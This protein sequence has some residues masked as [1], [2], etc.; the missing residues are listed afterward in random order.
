[1][2]TLRASY[3]VIV[4]LLLA[5]P[6]C[7]DSSTLLSNTAPGSLEPPAAAQ[8]GAEITCIRETVEGCTM[9]GLRLD[10]PLP[11]NDALA[12][13]SDLY[14]TPIAVYRTDGVCVPSIQFSPVEEPGR[15]ASRFAYVDA[16]DIARRRMEAVD[17][18]LAP[19]ITGLHISQ[20]YWTQWSTEWKLAGRDGVE[21][22][23]I[24]VWMAEDVAARVGADPRIA[25]AVTLAWRRTDSV[26]PDYPGELL[27]DG[28]AFPG[29]SRPTPP[30]C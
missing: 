4:I 29:L 1:M 30:D 21:I 20:S 5:L 10:P 11:L 13:A 28:R 3:S 15:V 18:G 6:G 27:M 23:G 2:R 24:A 16:D 17:G 12:V 19:P 22:E 26:D 9:A 14:A 25:E 8:G 7:G